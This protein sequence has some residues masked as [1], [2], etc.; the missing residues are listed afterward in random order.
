[1]VERVAP[2]PG[3]LDRDLEALDGGALADEVVEAL[4]SELA[5]DLDLLGQRFAAQDAGGV[6]HH[7]RRPR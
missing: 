7:G 4:R 1:M 3:R 2:L 6:G 5:L